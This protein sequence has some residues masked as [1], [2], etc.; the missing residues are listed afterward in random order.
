MPL[1]YICLSGKCLFR[2]SSLPLLY[3]SLVDTFVHVPCIYVAPFNYI[4]KVIFHY[5]E[6]YTTLFVWLGHYGCHDLPLTIVRDLNIVHKG[7]QVGLSVNV[8]GSIS[9]KVVFVG[10][11]SCHMH[12]HTIY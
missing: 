7:S 2:R 1:C 10:L 11:S 6:P 12:M 3:A 4:L 5:L 9:I 8:N